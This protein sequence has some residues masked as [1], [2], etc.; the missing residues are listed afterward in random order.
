MVLPNQGL[1]RCHPSIEWSLTLPHSHKDN[2][3]GGLPDVRDKSL[4]AL[5]IRVYPTRTAVVSEQ[6][7]AILPEEKDVLPMMFSR[8]MLSKGTAQLS[9]LS[10]K[11]RYNRSGDTV[12]HFKRSKPQ[13]WNCLMSL[14]KL[15]SVIITTDK[16][17]HAF[18]HSGM[19][20]GTSHKYTIRSHCTKIKRMMKYEIC[21]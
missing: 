13:S 8:V 3:I 10:I 5:D 4:M 15:L 6:V 9:Y 7:R 17:R 16:S 18:L 19:I 1:A 12:T 11:I 21:S 20:R 2:K 14:Q